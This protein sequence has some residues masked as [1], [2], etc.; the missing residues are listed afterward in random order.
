[1]EKGIMIGLETHV[2]LNT[3]SKIFCGCAN[4]VNMKEEAKPNTLTCDTCLGHPGTKPRTNKAVVDMAIKV[5][6]AMGC[7]I[8]KET[9]FS[10]KTYFYPDMNKNFQVTQYEIPIANNGH[11]EVGG[12]NIRIKRVHMEEDPAKLIHMPGGN[13]VLVDYNRAGIPLLEIVTEPDFRSPEDARAYLQKLENMLEYLGIYD[14]ASSAVMKSDA[15][16]SLS[17][18]ARIEVKNITGTKD[19]EKALK[20]EFV[21]QSSMIKRG[22]AVK[23]ETRMWDPA[24][25]TTRHMRGKEEEAE[26]GY[27][28]E[29]DL[30]VI[31]VGKP[32]I[33]GIRKSL[34]ELPDQKFARFVKDFKL[35]QKVAES[36]ISEVDLADLFEDIASK[37]SPKV[38]GTWIAGYLKKTLN[39]HG[40]RFREAG[41]EKGWITGLL[42]MF[43][44]GDITDRNAEM[45]IRYMVEE[46]QPPEKIVKKH[47]LGKAE[48]DL[49]GI[50][51]K[52][53]KAN[54]KA[55]K[56]YKAG[57]EKSLHFLV[58][59][60]MRETR[61]QAD[62]NEIKK[63]I[64]RALKDFK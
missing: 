11:I 5:A 44:R 26:Y 19:I 51:A 41:I 46:K 53:M 21:R 9:Y 28:F 50:V 31:E 17:G 18:G 27:I 12:K 48:L 1:M 55:V 42:R 16:I 56:D 58:G 62:A 36:I 6:L 23:R 13:G 38:A 40:I 60:C 2:Q 30:S 3:K 20:Y 29:P 64:I 63:A 49:T 15:N 32:M 43:E 61:G 34:P 22:V 7:K 54:N 37:V 33:D 57:E 4:P 45:A 10:R 59:Q 35:P 39:W 8:A 14:S 25:G 47:K 24:L 52:V